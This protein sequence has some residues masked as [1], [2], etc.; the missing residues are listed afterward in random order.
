MKTFDD[1]L[2]SLDGRFPQLRNVCAVIGNIDTP[3]LMIENLVR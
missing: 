1:C 2:C 3:Q